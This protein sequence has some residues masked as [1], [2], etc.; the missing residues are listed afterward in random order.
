MPGDVGLD[1]IAIERSQQI[2][3]NAARNSARDEQAFDEIPIHVTQPPVRHSRDARRHY[4]GHVDRGR[5]R[6]WGNAEAEQEGVR[7]DTIGHTQS[8]VDHLGGKADQNI[9]QD[10]CDFDFHGKV[11]PC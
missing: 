6:R 9:K 7:T 2:C 11:T 4:L 1:D 10:G 8:A 5:G 3:T